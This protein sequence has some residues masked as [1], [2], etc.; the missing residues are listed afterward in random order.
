MY[1][2]FW[3]VR[4]SA[5]AGCSPRGPGGVIS[6]LQGL[7]SLSSEGFVF[8]GPVGASSDRRASTMLRE[9]PLSL[10]LEREGRQGFTR[11]FV[12]P[13]RFLFARKEGSYC[14]APSCASPS[15]WAS[16][17]FCRKSP[18]AS[19]RSKRAVRDSPDFSTLALPF[20]SEGG[21]EDAMLPSVGASDDI[22]GE[23][24]SGKSEWRPVPRSLG[25]G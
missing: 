20:R 1:S 23:L 24:L 3:W 4:A 10:R 25:V 9:E 7:F 22:S 16:A 6:L 5:P 12:R 21:V 19:A 11:L 8:A 14:R 17:M 13:S 2:R 15:R 18:L